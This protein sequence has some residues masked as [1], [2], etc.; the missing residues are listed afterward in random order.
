M[1][2]RFK[3]F[4]AVSLSVTFGL[5]VGGASPILGFNRETISTAVVPTWNPTAPRAVPLAAT[6]DLTTTTIT[7][8]RFLDTRPDGAAL[9]GTDVPVG[10]GETRVV[11]IGG[12]GSVPADAVSV[13]VNITAVNA[14]ER[15]FIVAFPAGATRP[16]TSLLNPEPGAVAFNST[17]VEL[18][19]GAL[20]V[21]NNA[22]TVDVIIDVMGYMTRDLKVQTETLNAAVDRVNLGDV[23]SPPQFFGGV[24]DA[25]TFADWRGLG[26]T[27]ELSGILWAVPSQTPGRYATMQLEIIV[28]GTRSVP[29][30]PPAEPAPPAPYL[31]TGCF[32]I[33]S[34]VSGPVVESEFC[35]DET[36]PVLYEETKEECFFG[37]GC[38][39]VTTR[40]WK[41]VSPRV[42]V[43]AGALYLEARVTEGQID[44][45]RHYFRFFG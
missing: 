24:Y 19:N 13:L 11:Q 29:V 2:S 16:P 30:P 8:E 22:G 34:D 45:S 18:S 31:G 28:M 5:I 9:G 26:E 32:R 1:H 6:T 33:A 36:A 21:Y 38:A 44:M 7:P 23:E 25:A 35:V 12:L 4:V 43:P 14:T 15:G 3:G 20:A 37:F 27:P 39:N 42:A 41:F 40:Y 17:T 10:P